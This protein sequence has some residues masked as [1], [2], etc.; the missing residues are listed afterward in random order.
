[1]KG[2]PALFVAYHLATLPHRLTC[3][4]P[5]QRALDQWLQRMTEGSVCGVDVVDVR[6]VSYAV[7]LVYKKRTHAIRKWRARSI[8]VRKD[9]RRLVSSSLNNL[10]SI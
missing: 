1:M 6:P 2:K 8:R 4:F 10:P 5:S 9:M 7:Y 3:V